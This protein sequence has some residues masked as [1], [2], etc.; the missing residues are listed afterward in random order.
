MSI[1][2]LRRVELGYSEEEITKMIGDAASHPMPARDGKG[3]AATS[4]DSGPLRH[5]PC[6]VQAIWRM[7]CGRWAGV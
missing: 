1:A 2:L 3:G 4:R 5:S 7:A 6:P